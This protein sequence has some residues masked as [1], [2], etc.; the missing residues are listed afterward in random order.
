[1]VE[2]ESKMAEIHRTQE[3]K[4]KAQQE[5]E[6]LRE[7]ELTMKRKEVLTKHIESSYICMC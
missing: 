4:L 3:E 6:R 7:L 5:R 1:M 2:H